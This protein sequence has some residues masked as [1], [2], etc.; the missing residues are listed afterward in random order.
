MPTKAVGAA[1]GSALAGALATLVLSFWWPD[2][3]A[4]N[5]AAVTTV[6]N[7]VIGFV[8]AYLPKMEE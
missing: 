6:F 7:T 5:A 2:A 1:T 3:G 4:T 8:G